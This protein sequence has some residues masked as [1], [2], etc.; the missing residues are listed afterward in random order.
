[1]A[2]L[3]V[4]PSACSEYYA[5]FIDNRVAVKIG[6]GDWHPSGPDWKLYTCGWEYAVWKRT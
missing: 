4:A 2:S 3:W 1:V 5:A 6:R